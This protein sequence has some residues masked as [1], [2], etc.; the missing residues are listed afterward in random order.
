MVSRPETNPRA[1]LSGEGEKK[2]VSD[3]E[4][5]CFVVLWF[6]DITETR[7]EKKPFH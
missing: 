5:E 2:T 1:P 7:G 3:N 6:E 4:I